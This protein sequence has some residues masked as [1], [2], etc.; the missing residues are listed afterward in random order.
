MKNQNHLIYYVKDHFLSLGYSCRIALLE[1]RIKVDFKNQGP[2]FVLSKALMCLNK[3]A[4][5]K[6]AACHGTA[7]NMHNVAA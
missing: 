3:F 1:E 4:T 2:S 6:T 7:N 5:L